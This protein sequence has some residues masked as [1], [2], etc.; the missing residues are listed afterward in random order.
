MLT[1]AGE[2]FLAAKL[3]LPAL[4]IGEAPLLATSKICKFEFH[5]GRCNHSGLRVINT[6]QTATNTVTVC[7]NNNHKRF[8]MMPSR[9]LWT[10]RELAC[11]G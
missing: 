7:E 10:R 1:T 6:N 2:A 11:G 9:S 5:E 3:K 8:M 4:T